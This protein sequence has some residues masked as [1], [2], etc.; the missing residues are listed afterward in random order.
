MN[1]KNNINKEILL[2]LLGMIIV[3]L[4]LLCV[5][6]YKKD[7][8]ISGNIRKNEIKVEQNERLEGDILKYANI[9]NE[10]SKVKKKEEKIYNNKK[11][12]TYIFES[13]NKIEIYDDGRIKNYINVNELE[14]FKTF[15]KNEFNLE[16]SKNMLKVLGIKLGFEIID[17]NITEINSEEID[18]A[19][20]IIIK[21][22]KD[23]IIIAGKAIVNPNFNNVSAISFEYNEIEIQGNNKITK[24]E[25]INAVKNSLKEEG[26]EGIIIENKIKEKIH[27]S[28]ILNKAYNVIEVPVMMEYY[29]KMMEGK[30]D[31]MPEYSRLYEVDIETGKIIDMVGVQ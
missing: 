1:K 30:I 8:V 7:E 16:K 3:T 21:I 18:N 24:E 5:I 22:K 26:K 4:I 6:Y 31:K 17:N 29:R 20:S 19:Y 27:S 28:S 9:F 10:N 11:I 23:N 12:K 15:E 2:V 13:G 25:A 14:T